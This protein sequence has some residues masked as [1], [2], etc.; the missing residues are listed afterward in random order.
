[1]SAL[2]LALLPGNED[3]CKLLE[4]KGYSFIMCEG[5]MKYLLLA[6]NAILSLK[7]DS[8]LESIGK[9]RYTKTE[10]YII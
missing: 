4:E 7:K 6:A 2:H 5:P 8:D 10:K 3:I 1:V 9:K